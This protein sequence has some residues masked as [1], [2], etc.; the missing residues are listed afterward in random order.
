MPA[1][2]VLYDEACGICAA[3]ARWLERRGVK[4]APIGSAE[5]STWLR[6]LEH[7]QRYAVFHAI[8][9]RGR[10]RSGGE[11]V[12][13][14]LESVRGLGPLATVARALPQATDAG[15]RLVARRRSLLS[16]VLAVARGCRGSYASLRRASRG[17]AG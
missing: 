8:D 6:D 17:R 12:P 15:Y 3:F 2:L 13:L 7:R 10:R 9:E 5:G 1:S 11:A 16:R 14:V 4:T